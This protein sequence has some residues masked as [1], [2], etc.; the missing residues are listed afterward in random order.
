METVQTDYLTPQ[1]LHIKT[2]DPEEIYDLIPSWNQKFIQL[3]K[4]GFSYEATGI[5]LGGF[6]FFEE[7]LNVSTL[8]QGQAP[9]NSIAIGLPN[10]ASGS[11]YFLGHEIEANT[12]LK[13]S[14]SDGFDFK[15]GQQLKYNIMV[16]PIDKILDFVE[17]FG[18]SFCEKE[19]LSQGIIINNSTSYK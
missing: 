13:V 4:G 11:D 10:N 7:M 9:N 12:L 8:L 6:Q 19:L 2:S 18:Y 16:V 3:K 5:I 1:F 14:C 15:I 17:K